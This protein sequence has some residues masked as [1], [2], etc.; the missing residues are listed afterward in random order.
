MNEKEL[1]K[2]IFNHFQ[3]KYPAQQLEMRGTLVY[4]K[5]ECFFNTDGYVLLYNLK[6]LC[7]VIKEELI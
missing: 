3:E 5:G 4:R 7:E 1:F 2:G 6:R